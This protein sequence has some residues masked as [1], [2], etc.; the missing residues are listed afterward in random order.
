MTITLTEEQAMM[1]RQALCRRSTEVLTKAFEVE[2]EL[3]T[4]GRSGEKVFEYE[5]HEKINQIIELIDKE[6]EA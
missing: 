5:E 2:D 1:I 6:R 4:L 3:K